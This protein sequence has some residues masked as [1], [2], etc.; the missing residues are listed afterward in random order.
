[1]KRTVM[2][3]GPGALAD[4]YEWFKE[5]REGD[6]LI[7][8]RG[9]LRF[10]RDVENFRHADDFNERELPIKALD[11]LATR[12]HSDAWD[13]YLLLVQ[14]RIGVNDYEYRAVRVFAKGEID[15]RSIVENNRRRGEKSQDVELTA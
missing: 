10:D 15:A 6:S 4:Y 12:I 2:D 14:K 13:G 7:Y 8:W 9:D 1:M 3:V 5:S 11:A